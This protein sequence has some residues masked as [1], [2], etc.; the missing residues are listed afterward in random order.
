[1]AI[2]VIVLEDRD[3]DFADL[4]DALRR[5]KGEPAIEILGRATTGA[6]LLGTFEDFAP[7][8]LLIDHRVPLED[9]SDK[10]VPQAVIIAAQVTRVR[11]AHR[12]LMILWSSDHLD[13]IDPLTLYT[14]MAYGGHN[15]LNKNENVDLGAAALDAIRDTVAGHH[16]EWAP[17]PLHSE[18]SEWHV[19]RNLRLISLLDYGMPRK[20][21]AN[22]LDFASDN[23]VYAATH[24]LSEAFGLTEESP[25][26]SNAAIPRAAIEMGYYYVPFT[27]WEM[28]PA[29]ATHE[30]ATTR[31]PGEMLKGERGHRRASAR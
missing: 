22:R 16:W 12:P 8:V 27:W 3:R 1:V 25:L 7:D 13:E 29:K 9:P 31:W 10:A 11:G 28:D 23:A 4:E 14:F 30:S 18:D 26:A 6:E 24:D 15:F 21:I 5:D 17:R 19:R 20:E 2:R